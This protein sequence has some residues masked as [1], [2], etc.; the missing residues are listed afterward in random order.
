MIQ[1]FLVLNILECPIDFHCMCI[2]VNMIYVY[3]SSFSFSSAPE[4]M[5]GH[6]TVHRTF[7][8]CIKI[9]L[10]KNKLG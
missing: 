6:R 3:F 2:T 10:N 4:S 8:K 1:M 9:M 7:M 5:S